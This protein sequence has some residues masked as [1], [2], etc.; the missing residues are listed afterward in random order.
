MN[1]VIFFCSLYWELYFGTK[2]SQKHKQVYMDDAQSLSWLFSYE[3][4][5]FVGYLQEKEGKK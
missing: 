1:H 2:V 5:K 3:T 4:F